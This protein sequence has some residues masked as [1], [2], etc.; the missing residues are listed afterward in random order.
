L[1]QCE[2]ICTAVCEE[3]NDDDDDDDDYDDDYDE[4]IKVYNS[5]ITITLANELFISINSK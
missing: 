1:F 2:H 4:F 3:L 5:G